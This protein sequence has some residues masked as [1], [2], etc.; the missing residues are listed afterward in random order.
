MREKQQQMAARQADANVVLVHGAFGCGKSYLLVAIIRY[1]STLLDQIG[2]TE[3][4]ILV[5]ALTNVAVDRILLT[6]R[7]QGFTDFCRVGSL[8]KIHK[9]LLPF[10][11][12]ASTNK[13]AADKDALRELRD[14]LKE[15]E[16]A[17]GP[18]G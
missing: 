9:N 12:T 6:L 10:T 4:K 7:D 17:S 15:L 1:I 16:F 2:E 5:C 13:K 8:K 14:M 18:R 11:H 3:T